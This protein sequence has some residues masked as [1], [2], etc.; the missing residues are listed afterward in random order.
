M[1]QRIKKDYSQDIEQ[2]IKRGGQITPAINTNR[3]DFN[4][5]NAD[6]ALKSAERP[7][8]HQNHIL[9]TRASNKGLKSYTP[10]S[11]CKSCQTSDRSV[12]SNLCLECDRRRAKAKTGM[13]AK[14]LEAI[15]HYLL[16]KGESIKFTSGGKKYVLKVEM[17]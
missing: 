1:E 17:V 7:N 12:K 2:F 11:P 14:N 6:T 5:C 3:A 8:S 4:Y 9:R 16:N 13:N 15:G 10:I